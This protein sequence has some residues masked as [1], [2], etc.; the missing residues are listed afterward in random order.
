MKNKLIGISTLTSGIILIFLLVIIAISG[1]HFRAFN[2]QLSI[3]FLTLTVVL[4]GIYLLKSFS[5]A[6]KMVKS[7]IGGFGAIL[8]I[9]SALVSFDVISFLDSY[10]WL[11]SSGILYIT[12]I[13]VQLLGWGK[14]GT[15]IAK[16]ASFTTL[17]ANLFLVIYFIAEWRYS[18]LSLWIDVAILVSTVSFLAGLISKKEVAVKEEV[19]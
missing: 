12:F 10:N 13:Q 17:F 18:G 16:T 15:S 11:I 19:E 6:S 5:D 4:S 1:E 7:L 14:K 3:V 9:L 8:T 2:L